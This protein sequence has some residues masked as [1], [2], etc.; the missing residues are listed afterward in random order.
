MSILLCQSVRPWGLN[1]MIE[2][3]AM[4]Y[5]LVAVRALGD[6]GAH[7]TVE[8]CIAEQQMVRATSSDGV[9]LWGLT[10]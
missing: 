2:S 10:P 1:K 7:Q 5:L 9:L 6:F 3:F 8:W 4:E